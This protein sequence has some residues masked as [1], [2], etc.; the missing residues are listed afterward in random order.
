MID[1][2]RLKDVA[3]FLDYAASD[4]APRLYAFRTA[5]THAGFS[6][7]NAMTLV[8]VTLQTLAAVP[9]PVEAK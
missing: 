7:D 3:S 9:N 5:L 4:L 8:T 1:Q 6:A 2:A